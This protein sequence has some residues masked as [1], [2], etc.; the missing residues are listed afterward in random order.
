M[1]RGVVK[2]TVFGFI[3]SAISCRH[4]F[5]ASGGAKGVGLAT[6]RAVVETCVTI[7]IVNYLLTQMLLDNM[8]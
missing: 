8:Y 4:G 2:A 3:V 5:F 6:T 7:L 1:M